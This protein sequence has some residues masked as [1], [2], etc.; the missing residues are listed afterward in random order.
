LSEQNNL[1]SSRLERLERANNKMFKTSMIYWFL[2]GA[3]VLFLGWLIGHNVSL[4]KRRASSL[5][6]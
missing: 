6:D 4:R 3:G 1:L 2:A 5:L